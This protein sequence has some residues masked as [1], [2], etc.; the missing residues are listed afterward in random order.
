[1]IFVG[2]FSAAHLLVIFALLLLPPEALKLREHL[3][4]DYVMGRYGE[5]VWQQLAPHA[6]GRVLAADGYVSAA[7][8]EYRSGL[9]VGVFGDGSH[10]ARMDDLLSDYRQYSGEDFMILH[11]SYADLERYRQFFA[12]SRIIEI[13][14]HGARRLIL[15]GDDFD[16]AAY[17]ARVLSSARD[18]FYQLPWFLPVGSCYFYQ[19]YFDDQPPLRL[20]RE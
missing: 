1:L 2:W 9:R 8:F 6:E 18:R 10:Y 12:E 19:R 4:R 13:D 14:V 7:I 20:P 5:Q 3:H 11:H 17:H 15:L 16:Y